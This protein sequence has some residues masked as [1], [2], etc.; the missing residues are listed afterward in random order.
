MKNFALPSCSC[1]WWC[2][3]WAPDSVHPIKSC[4]K[5]TLVSYPGFCPAVP[6]RGQ[7]MSSSLERAGGAGSGISPI[8]GRLGGQGSLPGGF[9]LF[10]RLGR[11]AL[12]KHGLRS[13]R[14]D[15]QTSTEHVSSHCLR[16]LAGAAAGLMDKGIVAQRVFCVWLWSPVLLISSVCL[17]F[18]NDSGGPWRQLVGEMN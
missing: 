15:Y 7:K 16:S 14:E 9:Q 18:M 11:A 12:D 8:C 5:V 1:S 13:F 3:E 2:V 17:L 10:C 6:G 4:K